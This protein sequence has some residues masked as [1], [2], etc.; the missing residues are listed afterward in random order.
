MKLHKLQYYCAACRNGSITKAANEL[1]VSQPSISMAIRELENEFGV[2]LLERNNKGFAVTQEGKYF[3]ERAMALLEQA[4]ELDQMMRDIGNRRKRINLG[5]PPM[6]GTFLFPKMYKEFKKYYPEIMLNSREGGSRYLMEMLD[7]SVLDFAIVPIN[8]LT[9]DSYNILK[10]TETETVFCVSRNHPLAG[11][12]KVSVEQIKDEPLI[13]F[14]DGFYQNQV[15]KERFERE[16]FR[17]RILHYSSQFYTIKEFIS[18]E[19]TAGFMF[20][21][22]AETVPEIRG[23]SLENP[24]YIQIGLVWKRNRHMFHDAARFLDF[25][26]KYAKTIL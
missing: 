9:E 16:G 5:I 2:L 4:D 22:I 15:I 25:T 18:D 11:R 10:L 7:D 17:P 8:D 13:M 12:G 14:N 1:H 26:K 19:I 23:I 24:V 3:C 20:R 6:I 21:D